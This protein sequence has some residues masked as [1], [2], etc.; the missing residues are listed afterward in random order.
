MTK[1]EY[2]PLLAYWLMAASE[3]DRVG[4]VDVRVPTPEP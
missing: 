1:F 4:F 2:R 3:E